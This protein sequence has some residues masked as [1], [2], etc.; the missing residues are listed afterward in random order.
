MTTLI[1]K[2]AQVSLMGLEFSIYVYEQ[3]LKDYFV[4]FSQLTQKDEAIHFSY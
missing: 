2:D 1:S 3:G 4:T